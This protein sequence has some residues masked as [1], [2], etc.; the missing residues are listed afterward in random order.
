V[1]NAWRLSEK[2][3]KKKGQ[4]LHLSN[5]QKRES[6][7]LPLLRNPLYV[8]NTQRTHARAPSLLFFPFYFLSITIRARPAREERKGGVWGKVRPRVDALVDARGCGCYHVAMWP[9]FLPVPVCVSLVSW[10]GVVVVGPAFAFASLFLLLFSPAP[11]RYDPAKLSLGRIRRLPEVAEHQL[12]GR[13][14][15]SS[16][17][18]LFTYFFSAVLGGSCWLS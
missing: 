10:S 2:K 3:R 6:C 13:W 12:R 17:K 15:H 1:G 9:P 7:A 18:N 5:C 14:R 11:P 16:L 8:H 4:D